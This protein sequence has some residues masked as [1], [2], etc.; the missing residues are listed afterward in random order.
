V[1]ADQRKGLIAGVCVTRATARAEREAAVAMVR[2]LARRRKRI[3]V[4]ADK[5]YDEVESVR[6]MREL[7]ATP[8]V[9]QYT[10]NRSSAI[11]ERTTRHASYREGQRERR[12]IERV[13]GWLKQGGGQRRTR[14]RGRAQVEWMFT[15][16]AS[17]YN[18]LRMV[19]L[20]AQPA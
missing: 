12:H 14:F 15:L 13:F 9:T 10:G 20:S 17:A 6:Q 1:L 18:L 4:A 8:Q 11:D 19:N 16:A 7:G 5:A 2:A 3:R